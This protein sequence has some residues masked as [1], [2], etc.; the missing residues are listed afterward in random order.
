M[1]MATTTA[2]T[3]P[4]LFEPGPKR[5]VSMNH[6]P[7]AQSAIPPRSELPSLRAAAQ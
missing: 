2:T 3:E 4:W 1:A 7:R 5:S 6:V